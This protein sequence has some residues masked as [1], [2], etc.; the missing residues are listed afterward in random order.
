MQDG[1]ELGYCTVHC[2]WV[3]LAVLCSYELNCGLPMFDRHLKPTSCTWGRSE[4]LQDKK[5][6]EEISDASPKR[7][8]GLIQQN[9]DIRNPSVRSKINGAGD[10]L[11]VSYMFG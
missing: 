11:R 6:E 8:N 2:V 1:G 10:A 9:L 5:S 3:S 4:A 7:K